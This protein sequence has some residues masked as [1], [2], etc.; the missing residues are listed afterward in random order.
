MARQ[1]ITLNIRSKEAI[2]SNDDQDRYLSL[3]AGNEE[4]GIN[5]LRV[6]EIIEYCELTPIPRMPA[7]ICGALNL[8]GQ[9]VP[10]VD[11]ALRLDKTPTQVAQRT[12]IVIVELAAGKSEEMEVGLLIDAVHQVIDIGQEDIRPAPSFDG[13][14][15]TDFMYGMG[16][17]GD[18]FIILLDID[19]VLSLHDVVLLGELAEPKEPSHLEGDFSNSV[20]SEDD[21]IQ[22]QAEG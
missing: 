13:A 1:L 3:A 22:P 6:K 4:F 12:C 9:V 21:A 11:L 7:F 17:V 15:N 19:R 8:R 18:N 5:I 14:I 2:E 16:K 20:D 10:V